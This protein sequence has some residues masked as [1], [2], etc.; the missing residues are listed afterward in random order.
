MPSWLDTLWVLHFGFASMAW[1]TVLKFMLLGLLNLAWLSRFFYQGWEHDEPQWMVRCQSGL[2]LFEYYILICFNGLK[3][4]LFELPNL[5]GLSRFFQHK[6]NFLNHLIT[7][8]WTTTSSSFAQQMFLVASTVLWPSSNSKS[9]SSWIR[10]H[11]MLTCAT[12]K[13][14][15]EWSN[16]QC[17]CI[18]TT[19]ILS[20]TAGIYNGLN[21]FSN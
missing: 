13:S 11:C 14:H 3:S 21:C 6:Q 9:I 1:S 20:T 8:L 15:T 4:I 19:T 17:F 10:R 16:G 2:I 18:P 5:V 7:L 12:L